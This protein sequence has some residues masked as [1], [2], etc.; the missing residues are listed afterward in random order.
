M[1]LA[2]EGIPVIGIN[3]KD[4]RRGGARLARR[5]RQPVRQDRHRR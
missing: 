1:A 5:G 2:E 4:E 3:Y